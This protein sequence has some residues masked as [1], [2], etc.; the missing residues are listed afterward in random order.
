MSVHK[1]TK[2]LLI[3]ASITVFVYFSMAFGLLLSQ[4][5]SEI[6]GSD[7]I[8]FKFASKPT[9]Q[10]V[11]ALSNYTARDGTELGLRHYPVKSKTAPLVI[12]LH[13][14]GWHG[15]GYTDLAR[16]LSAN[17]DFEILLP[18]LRGHGPT[19]QTRGDVA[20]I[21]QFED[22]LDDLIK[23]YKGAEQKVILIGHSSGGGLLIRFAGSKY[24]STLDKAVLMAPF[25]K[26]NAPTIRENAGGW[27]HPL[28]RRIIGLSML[29]NVGITA[30]NEMQVLQFNFPK[31]VLEGPNEHTATQS[32]SYRLNVSYAPRDDYLKDVASLP[33][34]LL[35]VGDNDDAFIATR[36]EPTLKSVT[37]NGKYEILKN[38][39]HLQIITDDRAFKSI[40]DF[41]D[42]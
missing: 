31:S 20:Y 10:D 30:F 19:P 25:L 16:Y 40:L 21:G 14:S 8:S 9:Q 33:E 17:G 23:L 35:L 41:L 12:I 13:G 36:F 3:T 6:S 15:G 1:V 2:F 32:Y 38:A 27:A 7:T 29:N 24:G 37:G 18:D 26:Y 4:P 22:D 5:P 34:F 39:N 28:T 11:I 42:D